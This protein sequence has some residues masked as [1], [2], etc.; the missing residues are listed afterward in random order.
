MRTR[1]ALAPLGSDRSNCSVRRLFESFVLR[2]NESKTL[3]CLRHRM[4][5]SC[6]QDYLFED[7]NKTM[8]FVVV[9]RTTARRLPS[10]PGEAR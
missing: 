6:L 3:Q 8:S 4:K 5:V 2:T 7:F 1:M 9:A 10:W